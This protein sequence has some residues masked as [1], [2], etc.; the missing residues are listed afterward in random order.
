MGDHPCRMGPMGGGRGWR[1]R[2]ARGPCGDRAFER[3]MPIDMIEKE[4][5]IQIVADVPGASKESI[6][7]EA[8][9]GVLIINV[10]PPDEPASADPSAPPHPVAADEGQAE[11]AG[12]PVEAP[13]EQAEGEGTD[14]RRFIVQ[15][16]PKRFSKRV[17]ELPEGADAYRAEASCRDGVLTI[18]IP[19]EPVPESKKKIPVA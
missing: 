19:R 4:H 9:Q 17:V 5:S 8:D 10:I 6:Q 12:P 2:R 18:T 1:H 3:E 16:R 13:Q 15:Q 7:I 11:E 14:K